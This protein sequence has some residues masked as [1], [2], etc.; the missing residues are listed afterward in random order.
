MDVR[1]HT[2][3]N[4]AIRL[5]AGITLAVE[6]APALFD[7]K[8]QSTAAPWLDTSGALADHTGKRGDITVCYGPSTAM[9]PRIVLTGVG[10]WE[11]NALEQLHQAVA[12]A[13]RRCKSLRLS[14]VGML[15]L[16]FEALAVRLGIPLSRVVSEATFAAYAAVYS[17]TDFRSAKGRSKEKKE[18]DPDFFVPDLFA[19]VHS[20]KAIPTSLRL[21]VKLAEVEAAGVLFARDLVNAPA[22]YMTPARM[23]EEAL[24][25]AKRYGFG[26]R[27]MHRAEIAKLGMGALLAVNDGSSKEARFIVLEYQPGGSK[28][29]APLVLVGKGITFDSGGISLKPA[30]NMHHMKGDMAGAAAVLGTFETIGRLPECFSWP[31]VGLIPCTE[32]MPGGS[33][34]RPGDVITSMSGKTVEI[35][36]TD[37]EGRLILCDALTYAQ[38]NWKPLAVV[39]IATLTGACTVALGRNAAGVFS[40]C[41]PLRDMIVELGLQTGDVF[42][43]MPLWQ[44]LREGLKSNIAD[45]ANV[46]AREGGAI[47]AALFLQSF[48]DKEVPWAHIDMAGASIMEQDTPLCPKGGTGFGVRT[49]VGLARKASDKMVR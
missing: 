2:L 48:V 33:A 32:N 13:M 17:Y 37:A 24:A 7:P 46:G 28:K 19:I 23:A 47:T 35:L 15:L 49:L 20:S 29:R 42:W 31:V 9:L 36:N 21:A 12:L 45:I 14:K 6:G 41:T 25:L 34:V 30:A 39:D 11:D 40:D 26:C 1:F 38:R 3:N 18:Q 5:D 27:I 16:D 43:P 10:S 8:V 22:N 44:R 4:G